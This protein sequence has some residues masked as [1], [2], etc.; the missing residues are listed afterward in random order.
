MGYTLNLM[1]TNGDDCV[2]KKYLH[3]LPLQ[4]IDGIIICYMDYED[5]LDD[6]RAVQQHTPLVLVT[7]LPNRQEFD[8]VFL[9]VAEGEMRATR[10]L[11]D[12][13]CTNIAFV[14]GQK[15]GSTLE[16]LR[17]F[18]CAMR[19]SGLEIN[20]SFY[21]FEKNYFTTGFWAVRQFLSLDTRPDGIVCATDDIAIGCVKYLLRAGYK[22]PDD[23]K[24]MGHN[25]IS[26]INAIEPSISSLSHP[27]N[28][29][30]K[31]TVDLLRKQIQHPNSKRHQV[32]F[33]TTLVI[34]TSTDANSPV[35]FATEE[36]FH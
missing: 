15:K 34:N 4:N 24:V 11:I 20:P 36:D 10:H 16:K 30:A 32:M 2:L 22:I 12:M 14:G 8:S 26:L 33:Y 35:R 27:I 23:V 6:L 1:T 25:G 18:E 21:F 9:D 7:S 31:E 13:G 29:I 19:Q 5:V 17:G 28:D 3:D